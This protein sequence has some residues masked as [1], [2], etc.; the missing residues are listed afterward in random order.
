VP[1]PLNKF[2]RS[3]I[4]IDCRKFEGMRFQ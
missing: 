4:I 3:H 1:L 2:V